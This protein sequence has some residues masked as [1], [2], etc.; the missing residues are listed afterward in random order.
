[1]TANPRDEVE[2]SAIITALKRINLIPKGMAESQVVQLIKDVLSEETSKRRAG[3]N[4]FE[5]SAVK[6]YFPA[7]GVGTECGG[8]PSRTGSGRAERRPHRT[9]GEQLQ[10]VSSNFSFFIGISLSSRLHSQ[11]GGRRDSVHRGGNP[12]RGLN[13]LS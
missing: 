2:I 4:S 9:G 10:F 8:A 11:Y 1:M 12:R 5:K 13:A 7:V 3:R 6:H